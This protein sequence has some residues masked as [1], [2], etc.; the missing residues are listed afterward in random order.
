MIKRLTMWH[1]RAG[2]PHDEAVHHWLRS[3]VPLVV[4]VPG[5]QRY[6]Q[7]RCVQEP[8]GD[9]PPYAGLG[10]VW[11]ESMEV[12]VASQMTPQWQAVIADAATFMDLD[13]LTIAWAEEH[14]AT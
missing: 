9:A 8:G 4:A 2:V 11:F 5:V 10:E 14:A 13:R 7:N 1:V 3:H 12:A 6:V